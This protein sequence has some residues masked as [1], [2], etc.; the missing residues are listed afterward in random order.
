MVGLKRGEVAIV[1]HQTEW[2]EIAAVTIRKLKKI[3]GDTALDI[4]HIG[5]TA[6][7]LGE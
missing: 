6:K 4:Q 7:R 5:S 1:V 2:R 3:F